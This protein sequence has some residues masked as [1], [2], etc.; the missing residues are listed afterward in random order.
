MRIIKVHF[1]QGIP[2]GERKIADM[3]DLRNYYRSVTPIGVHRKKLSFVM[4]GKSPESEA[5][6]ATVSVML[7]LQVLQGVS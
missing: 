4:K 3:R 6:M 1:F 2:L 7:L 5:K